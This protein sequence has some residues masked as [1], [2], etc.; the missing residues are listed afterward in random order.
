MPVPA[1]RHVRHAP[2]CPTPLFDVLDP[3]DAVSRSFPTC[4]R[5]LATM[6]SSVVTTGR[7]VGRILAVIGIVSLV[8][9]RAVHAYIDP[10]SGSIVFQVLVAGALGALLTIKR[11]WGSVVRLAR[12]LLTRVAGR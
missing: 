11:W 5:G 2:C 10:L 3:Y 4:Y 8:A 7:R 12:A 6:P 1:V 9:P